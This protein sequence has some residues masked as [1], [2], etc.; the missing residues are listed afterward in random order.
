MG[1]VYSIMTDCIIEKVRGERERERERMRVYVGWFERK[2]QSKPSV[3][4]PVPEKTSGKSVNHDIVARSCCHI[5]RS[6]RRPRA[7]RR[8][9]PRD[10][11]P[12]KQNLR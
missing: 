10:D 5:Y 1:A 7:R 2:E 11:L 8:E 3:L 6:K 4:I 9:G 12:T